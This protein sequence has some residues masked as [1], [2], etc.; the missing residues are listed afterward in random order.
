MALYLG[1]Y[2]RDTNRL[3]TEQHGAYLLILMD[4]YINGCPPDDDA[5]LAQITKLDIVRW[6]KTRPALENFFVIKNGVWWNGRAEREINKAAALRKRS[7]KNGKLG[8]R[9]SKGGKGKNNV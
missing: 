2:L 8:G 9:P 3:N 7:Q 1:D 4:Y 6:K 5:I